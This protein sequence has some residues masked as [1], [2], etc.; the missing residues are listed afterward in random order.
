MKHEVRKQY[1]LLLSRRSIESLSRRTVPLYIRLRLFLTAY[2]R[3]SD[4]H[5]IV[6][7]DTAVAARAPACVLIC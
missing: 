1:F 3:S 7:P 2:N 6:I 4:Y 5:T